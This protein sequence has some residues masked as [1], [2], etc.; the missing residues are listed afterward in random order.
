MSLRER[1]C[2][3]LSE[4]WDY[5]AVLGSGTARMWILSPRERKNADDGR[6]NG[7]GEDEQSTAKSGLTEA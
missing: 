1:I 5:V 4:E 3:V 7:D 2:E 6:T